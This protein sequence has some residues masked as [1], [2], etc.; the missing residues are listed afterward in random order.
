MRKRMRLGEGKIKGKCKR[1]HHGNSDKARTIV[2]KQINRL[3]G[4]VAI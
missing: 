4:E 2:N 1:S 3:N